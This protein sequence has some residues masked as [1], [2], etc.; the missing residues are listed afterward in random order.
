MTNQGGTPQ[1]SQQQTQQSTQ[2]VVVN[3]KNSTDPQ[4]EAHIFGELYSAGSQIGCISRVMELVLSGLANAP[5]LQTENAKKVIKSFADMQE[6]IRSAKDAR[7]PGQTMIDALN[8]LCQTDSERFAQTVAALRD[9]LSNQAV[10]SSTQ[11]DS[12]PP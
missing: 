5:A 1:Q 8:S 10:P 4:L 11:A 12:R 9:Y 3:L 2:T 6:D 7:R